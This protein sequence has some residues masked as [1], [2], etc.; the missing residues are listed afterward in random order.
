MWFPA[1]HMIHGKASCKQSEREQ[2]S[3]YP[4]KVLY[5]AHPTGS[6]NDQH[7]SHQRAHQVMQIGQDREERRTKSSSPLFERPRCLTRVPTLLYVLN[8][9][10][11][12][13]YQV[14]HMV[15]HVVCSSFGRAKV[16]ERDTL[17]DEKL[18]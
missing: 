17:Q 2:A 5:P 9:C 15:C 13:F 6:S 4:G 10:R 16:V 18:N 11:E 1:Q 12:V 3:P 8:W 7:H 14:I